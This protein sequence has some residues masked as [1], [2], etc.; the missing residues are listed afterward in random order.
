MG[1]IDV[2]VHSRLKVPEENEIAVHG[3]FAREGGERAERASADG[4]GH[5][6]RGSGCTLF[7]NRKSRLLRAFFFEITSANLFS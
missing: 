4:I 3:P 6:R 1:G 2:D 5:Q 7:S